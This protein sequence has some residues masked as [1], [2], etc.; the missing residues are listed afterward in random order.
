[1][2]I[3]ALKCLED[4]A[5]C[6]GSDVLYP[7]PVVGDLA[8]RLEKIRQLVLA[9]EHEL[10]KQ[11]DTFSASAKRQL[12]RFLPASSHA[13]S[14]VKNCINYGCLASYV[15]TCPTQGCACRIWPFRVSSAIWQRKRPFR[16]SPEDLSWTKD[17][18]G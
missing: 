11:E 17:Q 16:P 12:K 9:K 6:D 15:K 8:P 13:Y 3:E 10:T 14:T 4:I 5:E 1:M 7:A 18:I 2:P